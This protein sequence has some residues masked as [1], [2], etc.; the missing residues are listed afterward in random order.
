MEPS[1]DGLLLLAGVNTPSDSRPVRERYQPRVGVAPTSCSSWVPIE[2]WLD[3]IW[4]EP[5][6][7]V[8]AAAAHPT[9]R[10]GFA[11][12]FTKNGSPNPLCYHLNRQML[13]A[14]RLHRRHSLAH[15]T[16]PRLRCS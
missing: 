5:S 15:P 11:V 7:D 10:L 13:A 3:K 6:L 9:G 16:G 8:I 14:K 12:D 4:P 2:P 1:S